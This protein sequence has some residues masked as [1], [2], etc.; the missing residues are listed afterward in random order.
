MAS[1]KASLVAVSFIVLV[2]AGINLYLGYSGND[3][4]AQHYM[5]DGEWTDSSCGGC[6]MGVYEEVAE[7][8][9]VQRDIAQWEPLTNYNVDVQGETQWVKEYGRYHPGGGELEEYGV[10]IDCMSCHEQYGLY[11]AEK[12]AMA[13]ESGNFSAANDAAME[14]A[15]PVVQQDPLHVATYT[16]DVVTP[17]PMLVAFH[18]AVNAAPTKTSCI[19]SCHEMN[20]PTTA[21]MWASEDYEEYD[22]HA[23]VNCVE[24]H[25]A[26]EHIIAGS[27]I[28]E[29]E[30]EDNQISSGQEESVHGESVTMKSCED[31]DCHEGIS[32]GPIADAHLEFLECQSCHIPAL[33]GGELPGTTPLK[34]F[35]WSSGERVDS[36]RMEDFAPQLAWSDDVQE[37][38]VKVPDS[39][40]DSDVKLAPFNVVT[41]SWWDAGQD[42]EVINNPNTS[43]SKGDPIPTPEVKAADSNGDGTVTSEEMQAYDGDSDGTPDYPNAVLRQVDLHYKLGHNIAGSE[44]GMA[45]PLM[46]D[47]CHGVSASETLQQVHFEERPD[48]LTCHEVQPVIDWAALGYDSDP[49]ETNPPTNFSAKTIDITIPGAK[50][51]EV[52]REPAF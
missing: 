18:D 3:L 12:R 17:L 28:P 4:L 51:P 49:A 23:E 52:E 16:L 40:N 8:S 7:S 48:C 46:C 2:L 29:S 42:P 14:D 45:E 37:S 50:P 44:T 41:G 26:K 32:H 1:L 35:N 27:E 10:D 19:D 47:D 33:P 31:A 11:D 38:E 36:Y 6:H 21:V 15:I 25:T 39:K 22:V 30:T 13:F 34:S 9:H 5:T 20:V 24:C 43:A